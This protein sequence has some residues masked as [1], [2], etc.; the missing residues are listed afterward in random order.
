MV[1][2]CNGGPIGPNG[3]GPMDTMSGQNY[4]TTDLP[5]SPSFS[6]GIPTPQS[7]LDSLSC[8][9]P[10]SRPSALGPVLIGLDV[11]SGIHHI[12]RDPLSELTA[13]V[14]AAVPLMSHHGSGC[15]PDSPPSLCPPGSASSA[16]ASAQ[17]TAPTPF[18]S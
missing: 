3:P 18:V 12:G 10:A 7:S 5:P 9:T 2:S 17:K 6:P 16:T 15:H 14:E 11:E 1:T 4:F 13:T 8:F